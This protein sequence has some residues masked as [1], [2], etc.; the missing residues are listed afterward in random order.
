MPKEGAKFDDPAN[1][2]YNTY[3]YG[4]TVYACAMVWQDLKMAITLRSVKTFFFK[5]WRAFDLLTHVTLVA[6]LI[7]RG[8]ESHPNM[9]CDPQVCN[10]EAP[11]LRKCF[12]KFFHSILVTRYGYRCRTLWHRDAFFKHHSAK[13]YKTWNYLIL[14]HYLRPH[15]S[16]SVDKNI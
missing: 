12:K 13:V 5:F 15:I 11:A 6:A 10:G 1:E 4:I 14:V 8:V 3:I 7:S 16:L 2:K 9:T